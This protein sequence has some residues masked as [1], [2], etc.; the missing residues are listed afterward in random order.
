[1]IEFAEIDWAGVSL[2]ITA[3]GGLITAILQALGKKEAAAKAEEATKQ[4]E[5]LTES[6]RSTV[7]GIE[8]IF[9]PEK[10][11]DPMATAVREA[12]RARAKRAGVQNKLH[13]TVLRE[14]VVV[15]E[16]RKTGRLS[17]GKLEERL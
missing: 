10:T 8:E 16:E 11:D 1:M 3:V 12:I 15:D 7:Q 5:V 14:R 17:R 9:P 2:V 13:E 6:L 4:A